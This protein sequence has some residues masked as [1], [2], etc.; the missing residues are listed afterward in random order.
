MLMLHLEQPVLTVLDKEQQRYK[1]QTKFL[2][3]ASGFGR[4]LPKLLDLGKVHQ[5]FTVRRALF[6][7][8][9]DGI[10]DDPEFDHN[11]FNYCP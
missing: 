11:N 4:I 6:T 8:I 5:N 2:L 3:D 7:H 10:T 9:E 1:I